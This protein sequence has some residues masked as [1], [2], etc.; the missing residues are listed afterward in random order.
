MAE[1]KKKGKNY[2]S[3]T[4]IS[5]LH[6]KSKNLIH[7]MYVQTG[8]LAKWERKVVLPEGKSWYDI[9]WGMVVEFCELW[10]LICGQS[11]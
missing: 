3:A 4:A 10:V 9:K 1:A 2:Y 7:A 5:N 8:K 6:E 11:R